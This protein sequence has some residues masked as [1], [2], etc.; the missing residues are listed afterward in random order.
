MNTNSQF[1]NQLT[2][3][4]EKYY[5]NENFGVQELADRMNMD[6]SSLF[7]RFKKI[8]GQSISKHLR[9]Y[10]LTRAEVLLRT[11]NYTVARVVCQTGFKDP[12]YFA[13]CF[14]KH[15]GLTPSQVPVKN[16]DEINGNG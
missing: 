15:F 4:I 12:A 5:V 9:E 1:Q 7:R 11:G 2:A 6:R 16:S 13:T 3:V 14:K 8:T 10:R